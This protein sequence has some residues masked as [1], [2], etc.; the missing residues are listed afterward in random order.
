MIILVDN[1]RILSYSMSMNL[2]QN[3]N[4][5]HGAKAETAALRDRVL[6]RLERS[7]GVSVSGGVLAKELNVTRAA[8]WKAIRALIEAGHE[9]EGRT[10]LGY[11]LAPGSGVLSVPALAGLLDAGHRAIVYEELP[12]TNTEAKRLAAEGAPAG[13]VIAARTQTAGKGR[14]G[15][16]F[17]SP[18]DTGVYFSVIYRPCVSAAESGHLT[19]AAA[20]AVAGAVRDLTDRPAGI[21]WVNDVLLDGKKICGI[22]TECN[23][24]GETGFVDSAVVGIG[25]NL[26]TVD[27][28]DS[29]AHKAGSLSVPDLAPGRLVAEIVNRLTRRIE[30]MYGAGVGENAPDA[31]SREKALP[32]G[33]R[34]GR[35]GENAPDG[36]VAAM[37]EEYRRMCIVLGRRVSVEGA[38]GCFDALATDITEA[39]HLIVVD[40][41]GHSHTL[42]AQEISIRP[43][44]GLGRVDT[45]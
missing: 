2:K 8:V 26:T 22:L 13:T 45:R 11:R 44:L 1:F 30:G 35:G 19:M 23:L 20:V 38:D 15:R 37:L 31:L 17:F 12:S 27:F 39:G 43:V 42:N 16:T 6:T 36:N 21:K 34:E 28:P 3:V 4:R 32:G 29:F 24:N 14:R 7:R 9:I 33:T 25:I 10:G 5:L 41:A 40:D 18:G